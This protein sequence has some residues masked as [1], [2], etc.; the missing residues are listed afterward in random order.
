MD[1][2]KTSA[3]IF[4]PHGGGTAAF[5]YN[6]ALAAM[7][8]ALL[9][10]FGY[11]VAGNGKSREG[12]P[13]RLGWP[14]KSQGM[15]V[16]RANVWIHAVSV[17]EVTVAASIL[18]SYAEMPEAYRTEITTI[19]STGRR[20]AENL[21]PDTNAFFLPV[22]ILPAVRA[23]VH[24]VQPLCLALCEK[25]IW[26]NLISEAKRSG[27]GVALVNGQVTES[28]VEKA[29]K[30]GWIYRWA[31]GNIDRFL[32]QFD[33]DADR[34][35]ALGAPSDRVEVVGNVKFDQAGEPLSSEAINALALTYGIDAA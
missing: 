35:I 18:K 30:M 11:R 27:A 34:I 9:A 21:L 3:K 13:E 25:E 4:P 26:P 22:D 28:R 32:M 29:R 1:N 7:S 19:T 10:W 20:M 8:P 14:T 12:W 33:A 15:I 23:V 2:H 31:L 17:G 5:A 6:A 24:R 16:P